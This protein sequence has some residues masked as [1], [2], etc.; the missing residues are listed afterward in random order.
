MN[1]YIRQMGERGDEGAIGHRTTSHDL[2]VKLIV[3]V[4]E[5]WKRGREHAR[6]TLGNTREHSP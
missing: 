6:R 5:A 4:V 2:D 3:Q 1:S